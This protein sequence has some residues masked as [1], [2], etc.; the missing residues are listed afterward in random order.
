MKQRSDFKTEEE[1]DA[2]MLGRID[3][4]KEQL[5]RE[6]EKE[7]IIINLIKERLKAYQ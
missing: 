1:F 4:L 5:D 2:Y 3:T 7:K 6:V